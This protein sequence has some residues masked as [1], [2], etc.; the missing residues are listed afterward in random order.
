MCGIAGMLDLRDRRHVQRSVLK[1]MI[2]SLRHR[3]PDD[4]GYHLESGLG[5]AARRLSIVDL[6]GGHQPISN[7]DGTVWVAFNGELFDYPELRRTLLARG[8]RLKTRCD[9]EAIVHLWEDRGERM[10]E[11]LVGQFAFALW[12]SRQQCLILARDR[13]GISPLHW[14]E[15]DGWL[16]FGSEAKAIL[17]SGLVAPRVDPR[18][19]D[20]L[21]TYFC[22]SSA[23]TCFA[24]IHA[25]LPGHY[26]K[27]SHGRV[28]TQQYWD[29]DFP[30]AGEERV[31]DVST[32]VDE[33][34]GVLT[35][36]VERRLRCDVPVVSYLSGGV[37]SAVIAALIRRQRG[38][39]APTFTVRVGHKRFDE[40]REVQCAAKHLGT[41]PTVI[42]CDLPRLAATY[43]ELIRAAE[44]PV[45]DTACAAMLL[46]SRAVRDHGYKVS[47]TGEG[48]DEAFAGYVWFKTDLLRRG[49][50]S[51]TTLWPEVV[52]WALRPIMPWLPTLKTVGKVRD[53]FGG[54]PA[55]MDVYNVM[56]ASRQMFYSRAMWE[57]LDGHEAMDDF[58]IDAARIRRWH[59]LNRSLYF[60]YKFML[61]GMLLSHKGDRPAMHNSVETRPV[62]L[63]ED[64]VSFCAG[65]HPSY[66]LSGLRDKRLLRLFAARLLPKEVAQ[67]PKKMFRAPMWGSFIGEHAPPFVRQLL[68]SEALA[69]SGYFDAYSV[70][71]ALAEYPRLSRFSPQRLVMEMGLINVIATQIWHHTFLD[72]SLADLPSVSFNPWTAGI[73]QHA[74]NR[75]IR[76]TAEYI[77]PEPRSYV[78]IGQS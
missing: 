13:A 4:V 1:A 75:L 72:A 64:V 6:A 30:D 55:Q 24:G 70:Q 9:T 60:S 58:E 61:A 71:R 40:S 73:E 76:P 65:I 23:R 77:G 48:A 51:A 54:M 56:G 8:H 14:A 29:L 53:K 32:L 69:S 33:L 63:D 31:D 12:D 28:V 27:A 68:S 7:E 57:R 39:P 26:L 47:L 22:Q 46:Q 3:G 78:P 5:L 16:L 2:E 36:A 35:R 44:S 37:D 42:D 50:E 25:L 38:E 19:L 43:P 62:F 17:S 18:G 66:K 11:E 49:F 34:D 10:F 59:P 21:F 52:N 67:R 74:D 41:Q 20:H 15:Q 45:A